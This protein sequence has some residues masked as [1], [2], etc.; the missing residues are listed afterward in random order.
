MKFIGPNFKTSGAY[1]QKDL[2]Y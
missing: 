1:L 2:L